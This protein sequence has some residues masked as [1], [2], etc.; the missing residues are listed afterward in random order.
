M[1]ETDKA[2]DFV[3]LL[4]QGRSRLFGFI[5]ALVLNF[6]DAEDLYQQV[7]ILLWKKFDQYQIGTDF[8]AWGMRV[9]DF[10]VKSYVRQKRRTKVLFDDEMVDRVL[11]RQLMPL[12]EPATA[13][14]DA[15]ARCLQRLPDGDRR[16]IELCYQGDNSI[17]EV[18]DGE[19]RSAD[20]LYVALHRI[21]RILYHCIERSIRAEAQS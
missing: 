14:S 13:R 18:A 19:G 10:A 12:A 16:L 5:H 2:A 4:N 3:D 8:V 9:A 11:D 7:V 17:R 20:A 15:L 1:T 6:D 21:R